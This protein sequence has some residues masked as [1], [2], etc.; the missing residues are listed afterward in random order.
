M[1]SSPYESRDL[2]L[3]AYL[4]LNN[5]RL[6]RL[7]KEKKIIYFQ[8][9]NKS[10]LNMSVIDF[11]SGVARVDPINYVNSLKRLRRLINNN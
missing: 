7:R 2:Y 10:A 6:L 4:C 9:E 1:S 5:F 11:F 3:S 8:F